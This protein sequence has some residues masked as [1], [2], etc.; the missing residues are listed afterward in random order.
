MGFMYKWPHSNGSKQSHTGV[1]GWVDLHAFPDLFQ[2][3]RVLS[4]RTLLLLLCA[5]EKCTKVDE[6]AFFIRDLASFTSTPPTYNILRIRAL[7]F[8][9]YTTFMVYKISAPSQ[10]DFTYVYFPRY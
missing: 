3:L 10:G 6:S 8:I 4:S 1:R 2:L 7:L 5:V 9:V